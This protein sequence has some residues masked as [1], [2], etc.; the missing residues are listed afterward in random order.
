[1]DDKKWMQSAVQHPGAFTKKAKEAGMSDHA[2]A[3]HV[4]ANKSKYDA[5]TIKQANLCLTFEKASS[6]MKTKK[7][8]IPTMQHM[9]G[10]FSR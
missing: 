8:P 7:A 10:F 9:Q 5:T 3:V 6:K 2:F 4:L 1:M